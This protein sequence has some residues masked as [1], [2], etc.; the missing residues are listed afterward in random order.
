[1]RAGDLEAL[2]YSEGSTCANGQQQRSLSAPVPR[3]TEAVLQRSRT[4][5]RRPE[6]VRSPIKET[7]VHGIRRKPARAD[8]S[9]HAIEGETRR[10]RPT[11]P[12][13]ASPNWPTRSD[14]PGPTSSAPAGEYARPTTYLT[15]IG[16]GI[17]T[18]SPILQRVERFWERPWWWL[19]R[20]FLTDA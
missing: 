13:A 5:R 4:N 10:R 15:V 8:Q 1:M 18:W 16:Q 2:K 6:F 20:Y 17:A 7:A 9:R 19:R 11:A 14:Q 3:G 12:W